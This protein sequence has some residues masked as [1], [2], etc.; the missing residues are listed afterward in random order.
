MR[1]PQ[2]AV[3]GDMTDMRYGKI[4][5][6][7]RQRNIA[8]KQLAEVMG[9]HQSR[10]S[11]WQREPPEFQPG[12][13]QALKLARFLEVSMEYLVDDEMEEGS[14]PE[15]GPDESMLLDAYRSSGL[16]IQDALAAIGMASHEVRMAFLAMPAAA[17]PAGPKVS[18]P[19]GNRDVQP[20]VNRR[21]RRR[22]S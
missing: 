19:E 14:Y 16:R 17:A 6:L 20:R 3:I 5:R 9:V 7:A 15:I 21:D 4:D 10:I 11:E 2:V 22:T 13:E 1:L 12:L 8:K 18:P